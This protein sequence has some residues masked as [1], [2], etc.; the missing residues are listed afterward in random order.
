MYVENKKNI[1]DY[2]HPFNVTIINDNSAIP[3]RGSV[4][5]ERV[6]Y[7]C[8]FVGGKGR[9]NKLIKKETK[10]EFVSEFGEPNM[11]KYGQPI[12]NAWASVVDA[13]SHAWCM[14]VMPLD[15]C[16]SNII[17]SAKYKVAEGN[18]FEVKLVSKSE[19]ALNNGEHLQSVMDQE[20]NDEEDEAGYKTIPLFAIRSLGRGVYGNSLRIRLTNVFRKKSVVDYR[21][22]RLEILDIE[23]GNTVVEAFDG[24]LYD[25]AIN[26]RSLILT[27]VLDGD[28]IFSERLG[29]VVNEDAFEILYNEYAKMYEERIGQPCPVENH[30]LF[31]PIF[32]LNNNK[33]K[34]E[35]IKIIN[36]ELA[37]DRLDGVPLVGG[38]DGSFEGGID[39]EGELVEDLYIQAF[40][41]KLDK[42]ILSPRRTPVKFILDAN[43]PMAVKRQI[44]DLALARYDA[45]V[46]LDA[47]IIHTHDEGLIFGGDTADLN[48]RIVSKC[49][50][51]YQIRDPFNGKKE[52]VTMTYH[53][54]QQLA[55]HIELYGSKTPFTGE[56]YAVLTGAVKNSILPV[57][58]EWDE[59]MKEQLYDVRLNYYEALA[60]N[61]F[62]RGTQQT[63]QD[64]D[65]DLSEEHNM[66][67]LLEIKDIAEKETIKK[68]YNFAEPE[69]RQLFTEILNERIKPY[70]DMVRS[71]DVLYDMTPEEEARSVLHCYV[72][73]TFKTIAKSSIVE[74]N[75]NPRVTF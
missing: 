25:Y 40:S 49:Y 48:Y 55:R 6:N 32:G 35:R 37:L 34:Q 10:E 23:N 8:I 38:N 74:L 53:L 31:D 20:R 45:F 70:K 69:D 21:P 67:M 63:A 56:T 11:Q 47:G 33:T 58:D 60:E 9:D 73:V 54:A 66:I 29:I 75:I 1:P 13:Y 51:H 46:F 65:S 52:A 59:E 50:Q 28:T 72:E 17:V 4:L 5:E 19:M 61:V 14:R 3:R 57:L 22:Y 7:L 44:V 26:S 62:A 18:N 2:D 24:C 30:R 39:I 64:L 36:D 43:Y 15:A 41:G 12:L 71:I 42:T 27:D 68:R 16:Y